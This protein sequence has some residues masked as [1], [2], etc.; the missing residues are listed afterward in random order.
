M[1]AYCPGKTTE[2]ESPERTEKDTIS[3]FASKSVIPQPLKST[4]SGP[5]LKTSI[6]S[7][8]SSGAPAPLEPNGFD[9]TSL[10]HTAEHNKN[11]KYILS[12]YRRKLLNVKNSTQWQK[13][14]TNTIS[15]IS[16]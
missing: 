13:W 7:F 8:L 10:I 15:T 12:Y 9:I 6:N 16:K 5:I 4:A 3:S 1:R 2:F 11:K 14:K